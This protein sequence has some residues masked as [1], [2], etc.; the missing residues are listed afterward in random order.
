[1][2]TSM[3]SALTAGPAVQVPVLTRLSALSHKIPDFWKLMM[4]NL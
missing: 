2:R 4:S 1:M 3:S